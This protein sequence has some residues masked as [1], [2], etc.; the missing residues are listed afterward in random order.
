MYNYAYM[1]I[2]VNKILKNIENN[3]KVLFVQFFQN[4]VECMNEQQRT[5]FMTS[6]TYFIDTRCFK[7]YYMLIVSVMNILFC[8]N[9]D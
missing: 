2:F 3:L 1:S 5:E 7:I 8:Y 6:G 9:I 4:Q